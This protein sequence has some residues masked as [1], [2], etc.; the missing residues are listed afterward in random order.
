MLM[1]CYWRSL[2]VA[3]VVTVILIILF[4]RSGV[5]DLVGWIVMWIFWGLFLF[6]IGW[7]VYRIRVM[8]AARG[9]CTVCQRRCQGAHVPA[10]KAR[11]VGRHK[12]VENPVFLGDLVPGE[13][14]DSEPARRLR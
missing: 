11:L 7:A 1:V 2:A 6:T 8:R 4:A 10:R 13:E 5:V 14:V 12:A 9:A 3:A